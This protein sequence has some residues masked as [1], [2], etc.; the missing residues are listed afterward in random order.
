M[1]QARELRKAHEVVDSHKERE[2][3]DNIS[4]PSDIVL[5]PEEVID[6][7]I[8]R[9]PK[10]FR[11]GTPLDHVRTFLGMQHNKMMRNRP[12]ED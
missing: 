8:R 3:H 6:H 5:T 1:R 10:K 11:R 7:E 9:T 4:T 2:P 12:K